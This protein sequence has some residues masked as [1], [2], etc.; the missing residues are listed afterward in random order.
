MV[1]FDWL[2]KVNGTEKGK[3][4]DE[5][6]KGMVLRRSVKGCWDVFLRVVGEAECWKGEGEGEGGR[7]NVRVEVVVK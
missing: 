6:R 3:D 4:K 5:G 1:R 7:G 2:E